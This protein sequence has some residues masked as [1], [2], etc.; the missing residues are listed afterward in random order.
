[1]EAG[2]RDKLQLRGDAYGRRGELTAT[3]FSD[4]VLVDPGRARVA[5][6]WEGRYV[7]DAFGK[8]RAEPGQES[9]SPIDDGENRRG[10][11]EI[12][13]V[14]S[15]DGRIESG[16]GEFDDTN[17]R[18]IYATKRFQVV[19]ASRRE[20]AIMTGRDAR[21]RADLVKAKLRNMR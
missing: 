5:Y 15:P 12:R 4:L 14:R 2:S 13:F 9:G 7:A 1:M 21:P 17:M 6:L 18:D 11:G 20:A 16:Q 8:P 3:W 10:I 19:R